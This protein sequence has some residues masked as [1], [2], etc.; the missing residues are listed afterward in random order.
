MNKNITLFRSIFILVAMSL[1]ATIVSKYVE[2]IK[3]FYKKYCAKNVLCPTFNILFV[4]FIH[5]FM[6]FYF[7]FY[8]F[9]FSSRYDLYYVIFY[10]LLVFHWLLTN[11]CILSNWEM[12]Y[13]NTK[14]S[15]G[16]TPLLHPH[17]RVFGR[18]YTDYLVLVQGLLMTYSFVMVLTRSNY[19]H[20]NFLFGIVIVFL[21]GY[22]MLKDR[23]C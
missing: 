22:L 3:P 5:Y 14:Q 17:F 15:I 21:Q 7:V 11:D 2:N 18:D 4:R 19:K 1:I 9:I 8:Y 13:Y 6:S 20:F 12:S 16:K 23:I 10:A